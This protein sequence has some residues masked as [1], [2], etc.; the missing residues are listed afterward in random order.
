[1]KKFLASSRRFLT[2]RGGDLKQQTIRSTIWVGLSTV[3]VGSL[4]LVKSVIL[5]RLLTPDH[6]GL[7]AACMVVIRAIEVFTETGLGAAL[8][9]RRGNVADALPTV[10]TIS[11]VRSLS[12]AVIVVASSPFVAEFYEKPEL[13]SL[14]EVLAVGLLVGGFG[15]V[16][17]I[18]A[19]KE[20]NFRPLFYLQQAVAVMDFVVT[21]VLAFWW[22]DVWALVVGHVAKAFI[23]VPLSFLLLPGRP[24]LGWGTQIAKELLTY[25]KYIT[26]L[27]I[28]VYVTTEIDN[29][30]IGKLLGME[31]LGVY[32]VAYMLANLPATHIAKVV[33]SVLL[34]AYSK[35]QDDRSALHSAYLRATQLVSTLAVPLA[36]GLAVL[37]DELVAT[38]YG[39][40]WMGAADVLPVLCLFGAL[41]AVSSI[42]GYV[43]NAVGRPNVPFYLN[44]AKLVVIAAM[45]VPAT[46]TYGLMGAAAAVTVPSAL[47]F[48][49][50]YI[51]F[52]RILELPYRRMI[53][54]ILPAVLASVVMGAAVMLAKNWVSFDSPAGLVLAAIGGGLLYASINWSRVIGAVKLLTS[55]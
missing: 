2:S 12:L 3:C 14:L 41:R 9:Q 4:S 55:R 6:F 42:N 40:K 30:V 28:V 8:I 50:S 24:V 21:V 17:A 18:V 7:M 52:S 39:S 20:L 38:V 43:F 10:Y 49:V 5:A 37:A 27:T 34:P 1:M 36:V 25:G 19:Q 13:S 33:A 31:A 47:M 45:I 51:V 22:R 23:G 48:I 16:N 46:R 54:A 35:L 32:V 15:N 53:Q 29:V 11:V 26:G 44:L